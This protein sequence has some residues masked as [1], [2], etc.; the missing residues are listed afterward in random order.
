MVAQAYHASYAYP[1]LEIIRTCYVR[2]HWH[3]CNYTSEVKWTQTNHHRPVR[4]FIRLSGLCELM[5][6]PLKCIGAKVQ[7][8]WLLSHLDLLAYNH[9]TMI[10]LIILIFA[11]VH[12]IYIYYYMQCTVQS[13][14]RVLHNKEQEL[15]RW[16]LF[17]CG[18]RANS[19]VCSAARRE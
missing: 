12:Y 2:Y 6:W 4:K 14:Y 17:L 15:I 9:N 8:W 5:W 18:C 19:V 7:S 16:R 1:F 11:K 10:R 13:H 3:F